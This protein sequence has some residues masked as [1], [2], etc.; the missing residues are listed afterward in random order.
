MTKIRFAIEKDIPEL[1]SL[2]R[3]IYQESQQKGLGFSEIRLK[4]QLK[5]CLQPNSKNYCVFV[6]ER[7]GRIIGVFWGHI[8]QHFFSEALVAT[9]YMFYVKPDFRGTSA[10]LRLMHAYKTWAKNRKAQE[11]MICMTIGV[12]PGKFDKFVQKLGFKYVGGNYSMRVD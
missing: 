3:D 4:N 6:A 11:I 8:D 7:N 5:A 12:E 9:E 1:I 2:G 10:A